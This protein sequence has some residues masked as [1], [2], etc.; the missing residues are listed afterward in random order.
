MRFGHLAFSHTVSSFSSDRSPDVKWFAFPLGTSR[1]NHAG[2]R[3]LG[4]KRGAMVPQATASC[5]SLESV[6]C[7][8][9]VERTLRMGSCMQFV[10]WKNSQ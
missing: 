1:R 7:G 6:E 5:G 4:S 2:K 10:F 8:V 3:R 9:G